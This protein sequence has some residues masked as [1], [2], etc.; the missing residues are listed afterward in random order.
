LLAY[1]AMCQEEWSLGSFEANPVEPA[2]PR[3]DSKLRVH[4]NLNDRTA[5]SIRA[6]TSDY[7]IRGSQY[8]FPQRSFSMGSKKSA[9]VEEGLDE[10][11]AVSIPFKVRKL[12]FDVS[13]FF[14]FGSPIGLV[15]LHRTLSTLSQNTSGKYFYVD[16]LTNSSSIVIC[17]ITLF[18]FS[19]LTLGS[20]VK[21]ACGQVY[22]L[23]HP[24][25][26]LSARIEPL[27]LPQCSQIPSV[28]VP[29]YQK[30]P[31]GDGVSTDV[32]AMIGGRPELFRE[33]PKNGEKN[34]VQRTSSNMSTSS[35]LSAEAIDFSV[36]YAVTVGQ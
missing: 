34:K 16:L 21:P 20:P 31:R 10:N 29:R 4:S 26:P 36:S 9:S 13:K 19:R 1:E 27:L 24:F 14:A 15:L 28:N 22:N 33:K 12:E 2:S 8:E 3:N 32:M 23:F 6:S 18:N 25:E 17:F 11:Y 5:T 7:D 35:S 30:F